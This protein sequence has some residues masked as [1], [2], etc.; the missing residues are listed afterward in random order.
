MENGKL[1]YI[2]AEIFSSS[3]CLDKT[4]VVMTTGLF[5][6]SYGILKLFGYLQ[7]CNTKAFWKRIY[8]KDFLS[9][10]LRWILIVPQMVHNQDEPNFCMLLNSCKYWSEICQALL[11]IFGKWPLALGV[12][13][14]IYA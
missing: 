12:L 6:S 13:F 5:H 4:F 8:K 11:L 7:T 3:E 1:Q 10:Q 14:F 2:I 9:C